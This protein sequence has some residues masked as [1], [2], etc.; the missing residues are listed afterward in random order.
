MEFLTDILG[1][2]ETVG[3]VMPDWLSAV[4]GLVTAASAVTAL[5][6]TKTDDKIVNVILKGL[7]FLAIN[8]FKNKNADAE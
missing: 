6:A 3:K 5:T 8:V 2:I 1:H 4:T 7:N